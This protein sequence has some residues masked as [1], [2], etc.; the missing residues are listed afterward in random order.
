MECNL[1][2]VSF[3]WNVIQTLK[4]NLKHSYFDINGSAVNLSY[5]FLRNDD[6]KY[7]SCQ[8]KYRFV[9]IFSILCE[10]YRMIGLWRVCVGIIDICS[11]YGTQC[12]RSGI[13]DAPQTWIHDNFGFSIYEKIGKILCWCKSNVEKAC[14][15]LN[16]IRYFM[17]AGFIVAVI[18][19]SD[20]KCLIQCHI[21]TV[22]LWNITY[23]TS[24]Y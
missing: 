10:F 5:E 24:P 8:Q 16:I 15:K 3:H 11:L 9:L 21:W 13:I 23:Y 7:R 6:F 22:V 20:F 1:T 2:S 12:H 14:L 18:S 17:F 19:S 4:L